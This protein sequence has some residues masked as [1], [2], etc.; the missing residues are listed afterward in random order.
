M[1]EKRVGYVGGNRSGHLLTNRVPVQRANASTFSDSPAHH[2]A[3]IAVLL[4]CVPKVDPDLKKGT[5]TRS[6]GSGNILISAAWTVAWA[7][8]NHCPNHPKTTHWPTNQPTNQA[9]K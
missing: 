2:R 5:Q 4:G 9:R 6:T 7:S 3:N 8:P 1:T